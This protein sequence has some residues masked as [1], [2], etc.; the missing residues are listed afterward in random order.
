MRFLVFLFVASIA[1]TAVA[2]TE[3]ASGSPLV[4]FDD[5]LKL[6]QEVQL[7][8]ADRLVTLDR[9][10]ELSTD[11]TVVILDTRSDSAYNAMHVKGAL[12][13]NFSD[14]T[15]DNLA[16]LIP[17]RNTVILIY[18]N[19]NFLQD[20]Q[21][22]LEANFF[23]SKMSKPL[24]DIN[25]KVEAIELDLEEKSDSLKVIEPNP[26]RNEF[27]PITLALNIPTFINLVGYGYKNI[28]E[29]G[30]LVSTLDPRITFEGTAVGQ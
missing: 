14:F 12:H 22:R 4:N 25:Q 11:P 23:P 5:Y 1:T 18:C 8:R 16:K 30:E 27:K 9:F 7:Y 19:N 13:L 29:L 24:F 21:L 20:I 6:A 10:N 17:N 28:Y 26:I 2:Q 15:Q 3:T